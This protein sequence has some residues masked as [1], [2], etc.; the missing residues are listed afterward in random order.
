[1]IFCRSRLAGAGRL[2]WPL[3][4]AASLLSVVVVE[5]QEPGST[6]EA[7]KLSSEERQGSLLQVNSKTQSVHH[8]QKP[9][10]VREER[11]AKKNAGAEH[12][13]E[14]QH[15]MQ[16]AKV[17]AALEK[18]HSE[19]PAE[20]GSHTVLLTMAKT[21]E[22][23]TGLKLPTFF[24]LVI[25]F[26][27]IVV[28][29]MLAAARHDHADSRGIGEEGRAGNLK[30]NGLRS[31]TSMPP[32]NT[33]RQ[34]YSSYPGTAHSLATNQGVSPVAAGRMPPHQ[35]LPM[36]SS[37]HLC[38][39]LVVPVG[40]ECILAVPFLPLTHSPGRDMMPLR[41]QDLDG[42]PVIEAEVAM[43]HSARATDPQRPIVVLRAGSPVPAARAAPL[44][45]YCKGSHDMGQRKIVYIYDGQDQPFAQISKDFTN[46]YILSANRVG[47]TYLLE[48]DILHH[49]V[50]VT[51]ENHQVVAET[52][53]EVMPF[54]PTGSYY[55][56][57]V[58]SN[59]DVGLVLCALFSMDFLERS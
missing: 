32:T 2:L 16:H 40:N 38:P 28:C 35:G 41:V 22:H 23:R 49:S 52:A 9:T 6:C 46:R 3:F 15:E 47:L 42:K 33:V 55:K 44:L 18:A 5:S 26:A 34:T 30:G 54:N 56:L 50:N 8:E 13:T 27:I 12:V 39:G 17:A 59:V 29:V 37:R 7:E 25:V 57:R 36:I 31:A 58:A 14:M 19:K 11:H 45:A 21:V 10:V 48:G 4:L 24:I 1:M 43:A 51:N 20:G 53:S